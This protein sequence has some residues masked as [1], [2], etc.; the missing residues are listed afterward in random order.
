M[1]VPQVYIVS[2]AGKGGVK[3]ID[4]ESNKLEEQQREKIA[5]TTGR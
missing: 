2:R 4:Q 3:V 1:L 5:P